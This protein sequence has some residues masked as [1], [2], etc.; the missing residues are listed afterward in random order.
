MVV[1]PSV[2]GVF[3][4]CVNN[5]Q[6]YFSFFCVLLCL[7][8]L[9]AVSSFPFHFFFWCCYRRNIP[10]SFFSLIP[11]STNL[12]SE[13][14]I[15]IASILLC[16]PHSFATLFLSVLRFSASSLHVSLFALCRA[17][18]RGLLLSR[19]PSCLPP[20]F[21]PHSHNCSMPCFRPYFFRA[22]SFLLSSLLLPVACSLLC[23]SCL[24]FFS[25]PMPFWRFFL[26]SG[27]CFCLLS[28]FRAVH[29]FF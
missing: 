3:F 21:H 25:V 11:V 23:A 22:R 20:H 13:S 1:L 26:A 2:V 5:S 9:F 10:S 16:P 6:F 29:I 12:C 8:Y 7:L 4:M 19:C 27:C 15:I 28:S 17:C 18:H 14:C 24:G